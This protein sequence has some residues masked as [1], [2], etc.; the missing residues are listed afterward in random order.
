M[1]TDHVGHRSTPFIVAKARLVRIVELTDDAVILPVLER[2]RRWA[3]YALCDLE[4]PYRAHARYI[5]AVDGDRARAVVLVYALPSFMALLPCGDLRAVGAIMAEA[6]SLPAS[7][8]LNVRDADLA[9]VEARYQVERKWTMLRMVA[10]M[11]DL[12]P[13]PAVGAEIMRLTVADLPALQSLYALQPDSIFTPSM[14]EHGIYYGAYVAG[15]LVAAAGT[16]AISRPHRIAAIGNVFTRPAARG[17]GLATATT[18]AVAQALV[19]D[20]AREVALNVAEDNPTAISI[21]Y[22]LGFA[23]HMAYWEG[24]ATLL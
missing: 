10:G 7:I 9:S 8:F 23:M 24:Y 14:L 16:H 2:E 17:R 1:L 3:A 20:G 15:T 22:R 6:E 5:G 11:D 21:Y 18:S 4:A 13:A 19:Q 12:R